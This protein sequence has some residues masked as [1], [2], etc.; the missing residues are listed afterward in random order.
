MLIWDRSAP[1]I[2]AIQFHPGILDLI[3]SLGDIA[4]AFPHGV[5]S[6]GH[7]PMDDI[8]WHIL[9]PLMLY[10]IHQVNDVQVLSQSETCA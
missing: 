4:I 7:D 6:P 9:F 8:K 5:I 2:L 1:N 3:N 10:P